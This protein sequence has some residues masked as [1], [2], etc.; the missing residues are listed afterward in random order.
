MSFDLYRGEVLGIGGLVGAGR[1]E[2]MR[3]IYG[4]DRLDGGGMRLD[5][6][7]LRAAQSRCTPIAPASAWCRKNGARKACCCTKSVAFNLSLAN[8]R[9]LALSPCCR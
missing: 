2:L 5:G 6:G 3:L 1:T 4:A 9:S 8:L 7:R